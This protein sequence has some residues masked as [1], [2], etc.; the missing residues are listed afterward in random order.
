MVKVKEYIVTKK[1]TDNYMKKKEAHYFDEKIFDIILNEDAD[2]YYYDENNNKKILLKFRKNVI[3]VDFS[4]KAFDSFHKAS[5][6]KHENRGASA[7]LLRR[8]KLPNYVGKLINTS[9]GN[10]RTGYIGKFTKKKHKSL[11]SNYAQS[12]IVGY[13]DKP[14]RNLG[15]NAPPCRKTAFTEKQIEKWDNSILFIKA[16][17]KMFKKLN[18]IEYK[19]QRGRAKKNNFH[20]KDTAFSTV[21]INNNWQTALHLDDGDFKEGFGN[22]CV[23]ERGDYQGGYTGFPQFGVAANV[24]TGDYLS[25]DVHQWHCN[26]P[27]KGKDFNRLSLV[28][29]LRENMI[30]CNKKTKKCTKRYKNSKKKVNKY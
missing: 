21:T 11:V 7:G 22:L 14:D 2:V 29:Y 25:M 26:T 6:I 16:M 3:P 5:L 9:P 27:L 24:R 17:D 30:K 13:Y 4:D 15:A 1:F 12:N 20:I 19:K 23:V 10:F 8:N 18:P 28:A